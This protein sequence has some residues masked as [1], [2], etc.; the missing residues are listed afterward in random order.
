MNFK[1]AILCAALAASASAGCKKKGGG[2]GGWLVGTEGLMANVD[3]RGHLGEGYEIGE[4]EQLNGIACRYVAE[5]WVVGAKGTLLYTADAGESWESQNVGTTADLRALA[6]Q[7]A[8]PVFIAGDGVF[9]TSVPE[10][11]TGKAEWTQLGDGVT[12]FRSLA[13]AQ[14]GTTVIAVSD[15]GGIWSYEAGQL[16]KRTTLA[17]MRSVAVSP[18]GA[19]VIIVGDGLSRSIDGGKTFSAIT[20]D[21]SF[22]YEDAR[23]EDSGEAVAVG[24]AGV[25][26]RI[27]SENRVLTQRVGTADLK[28]LHI[29]PAK[30]GYAGIGYAAGIGGQVWMTK[31]AGWSWT[32]GP[33]V[34]RTVLGVD[35]VGDGHN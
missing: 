9:M 33:N 23:I 10:F 1:V 25:V 19:N 12:K 27:D 21:A 18:N 16:T 30:D 31:D 3:E 7:D 17:G 11:V 8:G 4:T 14:R 26:S 29:A 5:A 15:D 24:A 20:V 6:T 35:E 22:K 32:M 28:T 13:A 2:G 34:G